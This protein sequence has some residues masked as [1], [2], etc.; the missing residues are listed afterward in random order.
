MLKKVLFSAVILLATVSA[1]AQFVLTPEGLINS[2]NPDN[3]YIIYEFNEKSQQELFD[4]A[5]SYLFSYYVNPDVVLSSSEP[6]S[7]TINALSE[8]TI[9]IQKKLFADITYTISIQIK[10]NKIRIN[11]PYIVSIIHDHIEYTIKGYMMFGH[12]VY[13]NKGKL[14]NELAKQS[15]ESFF[16][17]YNTDLYKGILNSTNEDEW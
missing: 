3:N 13:S 16:N 5:M 17:K 1:K 8:N 6:H 15:I 4:A 12:C 11:T 9:Q 7:I 10:D 2:E 14:I